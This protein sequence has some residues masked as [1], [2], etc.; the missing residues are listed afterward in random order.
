MVIWTKILRIILIIIGVSAIA[1]DVL[2]YNFYEKQKIQ[3]D[4]VEKLQQIEVRVNSNKLKYQ[5]SQTQ[6]LSR[7]LKEA[8][9]QIK[10]QK[11]DLVSLKGAL[12]QE[13]EKRQ[14]L[15]N[16]SKSIQTSLVDIKAQTDAIKQE[17]K[18]WQ[19]DYVFV[20]AQLEKG[21]VT[22]QEQ[23]KGLHKNLSDLRI[24]E[25]NKKVDSLQVQVK[26]MN[27]LFLGDRTLAS[28]APEKKI[29]RLEIKD[30]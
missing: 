9:G 27:N 6:L 11:E 13:V 30:N 4:S 7:D 23:I 10:D 22:I 20:L 21:I 19:K 3:L 28:P 1:Y 29:E 26:N 24:P 8:L 14:Q 17:M 2:L 25:L 18:G 5:E 16:D 15:E 12:L